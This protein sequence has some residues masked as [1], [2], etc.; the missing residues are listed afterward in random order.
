MRARVVFSPAVGVNEER[1][2]GL[3]LG[4]K[5]AQA[6]HVLLH[7]VRGHIRVRRLLASRRPGGVNLSDEQQRMLAE[8]F[9][10]RFRVNAPNA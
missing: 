7:A 9:F 8:Q 6:A 2:D 4:D 3:G 5:L 1:A 10:E